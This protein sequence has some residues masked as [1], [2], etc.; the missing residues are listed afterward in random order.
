MQINGINLGLLNFTNVNKLIKKKKVI[1]S[2]FPVAVCLIL[3]LS[4][5]PPPSFFPLSPCLFFFPAALLKLT[6][7]KE[8]GLCI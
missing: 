6:A 3:S 2:Q 1:L 8:G 7:G 5:S 4:L